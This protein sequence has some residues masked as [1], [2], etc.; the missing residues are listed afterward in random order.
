MKRSLMGT[1]FLTAVLTASASAQADIRGVDLK[2]FTYQ[3]MCIGEEPIK[4]TVRN[5][6]Y[7]EEKGADGFTD[8]FYFQV[9]EF[10]YGDLTGDGREE[11]VVLGVCN[12]GGTGNF[13]EGFIYT[14]RGGRPELIGRFPGGDRAHGGLRSARIESGF[15][16]VESN[17]AGENGGACCP[18]FVITS[19]YR[20]S[21]GA[22]KETAR[23]QRRELYPRQRLAFARGA[24]SKTVIVTVPGNEIKRFVLGARRGQVLTAA[25]DNRF[26]SLRLLEE[27]DV[28]DKV[29]E[30]A[31]RLPSN[32]D[33]T[34]ELQNLDEKDVRVTLKVRIK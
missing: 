10:A 21:N 19:R 26:V 15:L 23:P 30:I 24:S 31:A 33:Y 16:I 8:R 25:V 6:E 2:N 5:G 34:I 27:A 7:L 1:F 9:F 3:P 17:D 22:L 32:G 14:M 20:F 12:T 13:T 18:E 11:A 28:T 4:V 29:N